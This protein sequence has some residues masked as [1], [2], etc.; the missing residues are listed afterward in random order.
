MTLQ[1]ILFTDIR[2]IFKWFAQLS[3]QQELKF[4]QIVIQ[5]EN[6][7]SNMETNFIPAL[8]KSLLNINWQNL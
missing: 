6:L 8:K 3:A 1:N 5:A 7:Y 4:Y 2:F